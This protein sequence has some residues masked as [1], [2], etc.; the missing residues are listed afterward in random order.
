LRTPSRNVANTIRAGSRGIAAGTR[1]LH[2]AFVIAEIVLAAVLLASAG[3]VG[4]ALITMSSRDPGI[5][6]HNAL[7]ARVALSPALL[8]TPTEARV[9]WRDLLRRAR[10]VPGVASAAL[11]DIIPMR[12]GENSVSY[13]STPIEPSPDQE[14]VALESMVTPEYRQ[15]MGIPLRAGR[16][17]DE[18]DSAGNPK[19]IVIDDNLARRS[20]GGADAAVGKRL[21]V[22]SLGTDPVRIVGVVGHVRHWGLSGDDTSPVRD[23]IYG[24]FAQLPDRI[25]PTYSSFMS[26]AI[27][28]NAAP[29]SVIEPVQQALRGAAGDQALYDIRTM[30][31]V[32]RASLDRERFL[33]ILFGVFAGLAL[34]LAGIGI[35]GVLAY[36]TNQRVPEIGIRMALGATAGDVLRFVFR[37]SVGMILAGAGLGLVAALGTERVVGR[38]VAGARPNEAVTVALMLTVLMAAALFATL[39]PARS[40]SRIDPIRAL[41]KE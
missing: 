7:A 21:W 11:S 1:R 15:V 18:S 38:L 41:R 40:A 23:Q 16:F 31:D 5:D 32:V 19:V 35:Y 24:A 9:G 4:G 26:L 3:T 10:G 27:R 39:L 20:F 34:L 36:L 22:P 12:E 6:A 13:W 30:P 37:E 14:P 8:A 25:V 28:T 17:L 33:M 29:A 2:S